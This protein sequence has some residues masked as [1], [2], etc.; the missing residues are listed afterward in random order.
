M[1][2]NQIL[3]KGCITD[4]LYFVKTPIYKNIHGHIL[5]ICKL[6]NPFHIIFYHHCNHEYVASLPKS[7]QV[8]TECIKTTYT[9][10]QFL[11]IFLPNIPSGDNQSKSLSL[12]LDMANI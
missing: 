9:K 11:H 1:E 6:I 4:A 8:V 12:N 7:H 10:N 3:S 2:V 5:P